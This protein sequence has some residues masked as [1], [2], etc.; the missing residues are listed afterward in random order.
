LVRREMAG[1]NIVRAL[2]SL[3]WRNKRRYGGYIVHMGVILLLIGVT[4]SYA[5]KQEQTQ[6]LTQG[7]SMA[8]GSYELTYVSMENYSTDEKTVGRATFNVKQDGRDLGAVYPIREYYIQKDQPWTR[9]DRQSTLGRDVYLMLLDYSPDTG[10]V[11]MEVNI[12]PLISWLWIG[13][14]VMVIGG[15]VAIWPDKRD[16]RRLAARY[17]RQA[18][19]NEV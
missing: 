8:V 13:G 17:E 19:L 3:T 12:N 14:I 9:I 11:N 10:E 2:G 7:Q 1:E 6:T 4:G 5:F 16:T 18:R 15:I